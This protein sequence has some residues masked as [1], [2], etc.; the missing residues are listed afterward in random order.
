MINSPSLPEL[1]RGIQK[2]K[3]MLNNSLE[4]GNLRHSKVERTSP[5]GPTASLSHMVTDPRRSNESRNQTP[6]MIH[7]E[8]FE[9]RK[10][11][12]LEQ[13]GLIDPN[14]AY[15]VVAVEKTPT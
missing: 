15:G 7:Q 10:R 1:H 13:K 11:K 2:E 9:F 12:E 5:P 4:G 8:Y 6:I 14:G 3:L